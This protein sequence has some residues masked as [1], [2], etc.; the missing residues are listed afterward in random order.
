MALKPWQ[1]IGLSL[2]TV[3]VT[4][5]TVYFGYKAIK[6]HLDSK[7]T[8]EKEKDTSQIKTVPKVDNKAAAD[9]LAVKIVNQT[10]VANKERGGKTKYDNDLIQGWLS[11][12]SDL[13]YS[14]KDG[15][16]VKK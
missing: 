14:Y 9:K 5:T 16:A 8:K 15:K 6:K 12:M 11:E 13:G 1:K 7:K 2:I 3:G 10:A 4:A